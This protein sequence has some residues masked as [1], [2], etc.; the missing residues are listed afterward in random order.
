MILWDYIDPVAQKP[1]TY[2]VDEMASTAGLLT[3][4]GRY[5]F[6]RAWPKDLWPQLGRSPFRMALR[7]ASR[8]EA[9]RLRPDAERRYYAAVDAARG[10]EREAKPRPLSEIEAVAIVSR[11]LAKS[12]ADM[13]AAHL[14]EPLPL[15]IHS[16]QLEN[17]E[18]SAAFLADA[19][20][21][22][23]LDATAPVAERLL[24][25][26]GINADQSSPGY[27]TMLQ[28]L[29]RAHKELMLIDAARLRGDFGYRP[30]DPFAIKALSAPVVSQPRTLSDLE[31]AYRADKSAGWSPSTLSGYRPVFRLLHALLGSNRDVA[32]ITRADGRALFTAIQSLPS[33]LGKVKALRGLSIPDA[34]ERGRKL[35]LPTLAPKT[36]NSAYTMQLSAVFRWAVAEQWL[37]ANPMTGLSVV[38]PVDDADKRD[39]FTHAQ[40][41]V[42][43]GATPWKPRNDAPSGKPLRFWGPLIALFHG[44]RRGEIA[45]LALADVQHVNGYDVMLVQPGDGKRLKTANARRTLPIHPELRRM[46]FLSFVA[47]QRAAGHLQLFPGEGPNENGQWGDGMGDWFGRLLKT[48]KIAGTKLGMH[49][50]RHSYQ[51]R[52]REAGLHE[53]AL[54]A[55]LAGRSSGGVASDYGS[56][57][58]T[59]TLA[60]AVA[61]VQ[62]PGLDLSGLYTD[63]L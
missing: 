28:L 22:G 27:R 33:G 2:G 61:K 58:A 17:A 6:N 52:L 43:F 35:K 19:L 47:R 55:A 21:K 23:D 25:A 56:G 32:T 45:Q 14:H 49:A 63:G 12:N 29:F 31:D 59:A 60:E 46:G 48:H 34:I 51:D 50:L 26:E 30:A 8:D 44:M 13:D 38:D 57:F 5:Y 53:T 10:K 15:E 40:L 62:Y 37:T 24:R 7:T 20:G 39:P 41:A 54:G 16:E 42:L 3:R 9:Q 18:Y 36:I 4:N 1:V 11:Y